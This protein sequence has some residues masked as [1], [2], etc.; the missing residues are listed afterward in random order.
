VQNKTTSKIWKN[1]DNYST[2]S[3]EEKLFVD[4]VTKAEQKAVLIEELF[5][6]CTSTSVGAQFDWGDIDVNSPIMLCAD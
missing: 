4:C 1:S 2:G 6:Y 5:Y 3:V